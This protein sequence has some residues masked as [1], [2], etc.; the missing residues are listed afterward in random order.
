MIF[1]TDL[2][3]TMIYSEKFINNEN[4]SLVIGYQDGRVKSYMTRKAK[5]LLNELKEKITIIPCTTRARD[6][7]ERVPYFQDCKYAICTNGAIILK[8]GVED[9][10][11]KAVMQKNLLIC[12]KEMNEYKDK[13][14]IVIYCLYFLFSY[15]I[16]FF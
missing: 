12:V 14:E 1:A 2:D 8:D 4:R 9:A 3:R 5:L 7:F 11:W 15:K 6:Q 13:L 10:Q 16:F